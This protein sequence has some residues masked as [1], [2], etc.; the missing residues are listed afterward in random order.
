MK[1]A[2]QIIEA[3]L[4]YVHCGLLNLTVRIRRDD[5]K[6]LTT[7]ASIKL[8]DKNI[9]DALNFLTKAY[10]SAPNDELTTFSIGGILQIS[11]HADAAL[12]KYRS[13]GQKTDMKA[14]S[15]YLLSNIGMAFYAK[16]KFTAA[17]IYLKKAHYLAPLDFRISFNLGLVHI[18]LEQYASAFVFLSASVNL[19]NK[20]AAGFGWMAVALFHL[21]DAENA[22]AAFQRALQLDENDCAIRLNYAS[23]L[24]STD[25]F[26]EAN[27]HVLTALQNLPGP[28]SDSIEKVPRQSLLDYAEK[29]GAKLAS[30]GL[31]TVLELMT[32]DSV[33]SDS[34]QSLDDFITV[35]P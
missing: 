14:S 24:L 23:Y 10:L 4:K 29:L 19:N 9:P 25:S 2:M 7:A 28:D 26:D 27:T 3:C 11:G 12:V 13:I 32:K 1:S 17:V 35:S 30:K 33:V 16:R 6:M 20:F 18:S 15:P 21:D 31:G 8:F 5:A 22:D 34:S